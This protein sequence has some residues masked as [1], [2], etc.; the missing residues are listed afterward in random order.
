MTRRR[1][2]AALLVLALAA[3]GCGGDDEKPPARGDTGAERTVPPGGDTERQPT[4][5]E[6]PPPEKGQAERPPPEEGEGGAGDEEP[7]RSDA[8][9]TAGGGRISPRLVRVPPFVAVRIELRSGD[10]RAYGLVVK[11][12]TLQVGPGK[13]RASVLLEGLRPGRRYTGAPV[14]ARNTVAVEASA[15]PGP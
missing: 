14:G 6:R 13:R 10:G 4:Q 3:A 15:E 8:V 1:A 11:G 5:T 7:I 2:L 9:F 12:R